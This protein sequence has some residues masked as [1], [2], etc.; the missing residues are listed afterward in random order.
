M[1]PTKKYI[2]ELPTSVALEYDHQ[3]DILHIILGHR[4]EQPDEEVLS[5]DS[6][7]VFGLKNNKL[8]VISILN[9]SKKLEES[10]V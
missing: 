4:E 2:V 8:L 6:N 10:S 5:E 7:V 1:T 9:F 3:T